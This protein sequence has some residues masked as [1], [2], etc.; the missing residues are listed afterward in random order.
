M[1]NVSDKNTLAKKSAKPLAESA[2]LAA[3]APIAPNTNTSDVMSKATRWSF[4]QNDLE[5]A[6]NNWEDLEKTQN[7]LS[8]EEEQF[9]KIKNI[10]GQL[11]EKINQF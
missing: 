11:K 9:E 8:P 6:L 7:N 1:S 3:P 10:I 5:K 2:K 4:I